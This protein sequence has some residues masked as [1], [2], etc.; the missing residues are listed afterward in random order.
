M[1]LAFF[2]GHH[3][4]GS[5]SIQTYLARHYLPLLQAGILY[6]AVESSGVASNLATVLHAEAQAQAENLS[7]REPHN[8]LAFGLISEAL[9]KEVPPWHNN[10]P[11]GFQM[12]QMIDAQI[13]ALAPKHTIIC[14]EVMSRFAEQGW[15]KIMPRIH[16]RFAHHDCS[17]VLNLRRIDDYLASWQLQTLKFGAVIDPLRHGAQAKFYQTAHFQYD[18][19]VARWSKAL[20]QARMVVRNYA[21]VMAAG[22]SVVDFF[23]QSRIDYA[24]TN[25][26]PHL[27]TSL[28]YAFAE[29]LRKANVAIPKHRSEMLNY[30]L[31]AAQRIDL[32]PSSEVE[33]FGASHRAALLKAF[34]PV[35]N[36]LSDFLGLEAFFPD[37]DEIALCR[38]IPEMTA[39]ATA[40]QALQQDAADCAPSAE[41]RDF[42]M[43][44]V[45]EP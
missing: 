36:R 37:L 15:P 40:L 24:P 32:I 42:V 11:S 2:I 45:L 26:L 22:G 29:I 14:S 10:L 31:G 9:K 21:D 12:F 39:A 18:S 35:H 25:P 7:I 27:N 3:K 33:L 30:L 5:T 34:A 41:V 13:H 16:N 44:L 28:P 38:P 43:T 1:K 4:T 20:P 17:I 23:A 19:I 8:A 6:P